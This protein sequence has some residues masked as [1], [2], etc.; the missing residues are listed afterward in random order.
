MAEDVQITLTP[1]KRAV[2]PLAVGTVISFLVITSFGTILG[3][4][5]WPGIIAVY[6]QANKAL[7]A[8]SYFV[9]LVTIVLAFTFISWL[10]VVGERSR[11]ERPLS[12]VLRQNVQFLLIA[13]LVTAVAFFEAVLTF[14]RREAS[15]FVVVQIGNATQLDFLSTTWAVA[16]GFVLPAALLFLILVGTARLSSSTSGA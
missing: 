5:A 11:P 6:R 16:L 10:E 15:N 12:R 3:V 8:A 2:V 1:L 14:I 13:K 7:G 4:A 9:N